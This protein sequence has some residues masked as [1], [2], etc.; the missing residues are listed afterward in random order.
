MR[1]LFVTTSPNSVLNRLRTIS[2]IDLCVVDCAENYITVGERIEEA[3][4]AQTPDLIL[5]YRCP[6][7]LPESVFTIAR[8]GAYNLHPSLLPKYSGLNPWKDIFANKESVSGVTLHRISSN[9]DGGEIIYQVEYSIDPCDTIDKARYKADCL[10]TELTIL[11][12]E[13]ISSR[14]F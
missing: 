7:I 9:I 4:T 14:F 2:S 10:A 1:V 13:H 12:M 8:L 3:I 11:L 5:V 6:Y